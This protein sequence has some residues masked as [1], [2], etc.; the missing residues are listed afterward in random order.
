MHH[1]M[2]DKIIQVSPKTIVIGIDIAKYKHYACTVDNRDLVFERPISPPKGFTVF[3]RRFFYF[4]RR[5]R[6]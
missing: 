1:K 4:G 2:N 5:T 3:S 6:K